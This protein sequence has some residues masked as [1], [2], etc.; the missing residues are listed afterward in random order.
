MRAFGDALE[1]IPMALAENSGLAPIQTVAGMRS[2]QATE[3]NPRL[4]I[5]CMQKATCGR[6]QQHKNILK[7]ARARDTNLLY[8]LKIA[9]MNNR[10]RWAG[11]IPRTV[12]IPQ[13]A[14]SL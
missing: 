3:N 5:D 9:E 12:Y 14:Q 13:T 2:R 7:L 10:G 6:Q 8:L 1:S 11:Y 4:G